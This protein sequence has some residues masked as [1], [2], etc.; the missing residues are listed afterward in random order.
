MIQD[1]TKL[2]YHSNAVTI[3][4]HTKPGTAKTYGMLECVNLTVRTIIIY[5]SKHAPSA[6]LDMYFVEFLVFYNTHMCHGALVKEFIVKTP[7]AHVASGC[8]LN[9][10]CLRN[11]FCSL[12][13]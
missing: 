2:F 13:I 11:T 3:Y 7:L 1:A 4:R 6:D 9:L 12:E 5:K 10:N 8:L